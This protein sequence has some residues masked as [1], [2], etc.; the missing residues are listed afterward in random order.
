MNQLLLERDPLRGLLASALGPLGGTLLWLLV[1]LVSAV[2]YPWAWAWF[3][4]RG[5]HRH[6]DEREH[7]MAWTAVAAAC[8]LLTAGVAVAR[9]AEPPALVAQAAV[10]APDS[11]IGG[12]RSPRHC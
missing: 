12:H 9:H 5:W 10:H 3:Q 2:L 4:L 11:C 1:R 6:H 8:A 7:R